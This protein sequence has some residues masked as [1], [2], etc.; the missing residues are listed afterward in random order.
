MGTIKFTDPSPFLDVN[1][2]PP[3][4]SRIYVYAA[5]TERLTP[6]YE[7]SALT[8]LRANPIK[9]SIS[10]GFAPFYLM[11]GY[12]RIVV[13]DFQ[14][15]VVLEENNV[16]VIPTDENLASRRF[17]KVS[18]I[19]ADTTLSYI[20]GFG[21]QQVKPGDI[22]HA[23]QGAFSYEI[24][25]ASTPTATLITGGGVKLGQL[26]KWNPRAL[27]DFADHRPQV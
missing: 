18:D 5:G 4:N 20:G 13:M 8:I 19:I 16:E 11:E 12:Y 17:E 21:R 3:P 24:L 14:D 7:D 9:T 23:D 25:P 1:Y 26:G 10:G 15:N 27:G 2:A 6:I 22:V